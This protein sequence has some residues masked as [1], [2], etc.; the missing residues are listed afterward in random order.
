M[1]SGS[2]QPSA[3]RRTF[4]C[5]STGNILSAFLIPIQWH[6]NTGWDWYTFNAPLRPFYVRLSGTLFTRHLGARACGDPSGL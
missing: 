2:H 3:T 1:G 5:K 4:T 6:K